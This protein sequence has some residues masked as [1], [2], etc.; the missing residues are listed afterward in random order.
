MRPLT[1][2][3]IGIA[4]L[5]ALGVV[6]SAHRMIQKR[7]LAAAA[8]QDAGAQDAEVLVAAKAIAQGTI[9][10]DGDLQWAHWP[11]HTAQAG[12]VIV[13]KAS[14]SALD[15]APGSAARRNLLVGEPITAN[16]L[17]TPGH[18]NGFMATMIAP[19][20]K[21]VGVTVTAA[22]TASGFVLP[23]DMVDV[24][25]TVDLKKAEVN[26]PG[27]G[28]F[29]SEAVLKSVKVLAVD[30]MLTRASNGAAK[31]KRPRR[32]QAQSQTQSQSADDAANEDVSMVGKTVALEVTP[33]EADRLL[34]A[35]AVGS[36]SLVL[37]SLAQVDGADEGDLP[38]TADVD[39]SRALRTAVGGGI[40][41]VKGGQVEH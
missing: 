31:S 35:Q 30:Q 37:R 3:F 38:F 28:R 5:A 29:A 19:G 4:A 6:F 27:G 24:I 34:A 36:L 25:L 2:V 14:A 18:G 15:Q 11:M 7:A 40:R 21:A 9:L 23:G 17:F 16:A 12:G 10:K 32:D 33:E 13:R 1:L 39:T 22:S 20:K 8:L 26:L 41:I